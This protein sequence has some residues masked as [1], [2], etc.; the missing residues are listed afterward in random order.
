MFYKANINQ[1]LD[2]YVEMGGQNAVASSSN[3]SHGPQSDYEP[4]MHPPATV[5]HPKPDL[6]GLTAVIGT[7]NDFPMVSLNMGY[8]FS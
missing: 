8:V 5:A 1:I 7:G 6:V 2:D 4:T 3:T